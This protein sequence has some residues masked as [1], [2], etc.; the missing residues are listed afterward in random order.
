MKPIEHSSY[1][2]DCFKKKFTPRGKVGAQ[3]PTWLCP[4]EATIH[5]LPAATAD[6]SVLLTQT[7]QKPRF[8]QEG[9]HLYKQQGNSG[10]RGPQPLCHHLYFSIPKNLVPLQFSNEKTTLPWS[11]GT[12]SLAFVPTAPWGQRCIKKE[13]HLF[14]KESETWLGDLLFK[15]IKNR[16]NCLGHSG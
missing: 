11:P 7:L 9:S 15:T 14:G 5:H 8:K 4:T 12:A 2:S 10:S 1:T 16:K 3:A 13:F 6:T